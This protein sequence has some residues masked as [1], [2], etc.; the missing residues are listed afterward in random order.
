LTQTHYQTLGVP[1][2]ATQQEIKSAFHKLAMRH[3]PDVTHMDK[4]K[5]EEIF[6]VVSMAYWV[7]KD[8][9][10]RRQY[11]RTLSNQARNVRVT[12]SGPP[13]WETQ[14]WFW[15]ERS[16]RYRRKPPED[17]DSYVARTPFGF[18]R[19]RGHR[20]ETRWERFRGSIIARM[21]S[22][23]F[24]FLRRGR[25]ARLRY[26]LFLDWAFKKRNHFM[27]ANKPHKIR[28]PRLN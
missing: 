23:G 16:L 19:K 10:R 2:G 13:P 17:D 1:F 21:Q 11:D 20:S 9:T 15:D 14:E 22:I 7:L 27:R 12:Y 24:W 5:A 18:I 6:K 25:S 26:V 3:H 28:K 8:P 4:E